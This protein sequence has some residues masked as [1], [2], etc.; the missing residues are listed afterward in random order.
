MKPAKPAG[1]ILAGGRSSRMRVT[2]KALLKLHGQT[3][4]ERVIDRFQSYTEPLLISCESDTG[5]FDDYGLTVVPDLLPGFHG[6]LI[7]LYSAL[8]LLID[9]G[10]NTGLV[11][12]PCDAP[13]VPHNL[14]QTLLD[15]VQDDHDS[16]AVVSYQGVL[17][18]TFSMWQNHHL[19]AIHEAVVNRG[20][21]GLKHMLTSMPHTIVEWT[22]TQPPPFFNV[23]T[24]EELQTAET[25]LD[26]LPA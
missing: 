10:Q 17:Q 1:V 22:P 12:F 20:I 16:V 6:P 26:R 3:L 19:P 15:T 5:D 8:Q 25:W 2:R 23:N 4:L 18:P 21:G 24:P 11:L 9:R 14:V 7:G 13:F